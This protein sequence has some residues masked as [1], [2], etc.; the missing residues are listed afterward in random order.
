MKEGRTEMKGVEET[1]TSGS[2]LTFF[3]HLS[4]SPS[5]PPPSVASICLSFL[6]FPA[7]CLPCLAFFAVPFSPR[8]NMKSNRLFFFRVSVQANSNLSGERIERV[9]RLFE[10]RRVGLLLGVC[11]GGA[12]LPVSSVGD[13]EDASE[14][15]AVEGRSAISERVLI[16]ERGGGGGGGEG[17]RARRTGQTEDRTSAQPV[18]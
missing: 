9:E 12:R 13:A 18:A 10:R 3:S 5:P 8:T 16:R 14:D 17:G 15:V 11:L 1:T 7:L 4:P 6:L 2:Y